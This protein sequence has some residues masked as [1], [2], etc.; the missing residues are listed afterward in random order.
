MSLQVGSTLHH[1][2]TINRAALIAFNQSVGDD[3]HLKDDQPLTARS[4]FAAGLVSRLLDDEIP[5]KHVLLS[6]SMKFHDAVQEDDLI[7][8]TAEV[9]SVQNHMCTLIFQLRRDQKL[10]ISGEAVVQVEG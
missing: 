7:T 5:G 3:S 6:Q 4:V 10:I 8:A 1:S 9:T 2:Y